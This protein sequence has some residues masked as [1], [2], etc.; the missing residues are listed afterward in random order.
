[1]TT[2]PTQDEIIAALKIMNVSGE[3]LLNGMSETTTPAQF[4]ALADDADQLAT[5]FRVLA[6]ASID[7]I[8]AAAQVIENNGP[9]P[10]CPPPPPPPMS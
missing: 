8:T 7:A 4:E 3:A 10:P 6:N 1:M 5:G 9:N 2:V